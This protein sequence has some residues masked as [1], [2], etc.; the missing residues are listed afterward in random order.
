MATINNEDKQTRLGKAA[1]FFKQ[2]Q[3]IVLSVVIVVLVIIVTHMIIIE[4]RKKYIIVDAIEVPESLTQKGYN[5]S[6]IAR[7]LIDEMNRLKYVAEDSATY[8]LNPQD[9]SPTIGVSKEMNDLNFQIPETDISFSSILGFFRHYFNNKQITI[10]GD[11]IV[12]DKTV[13]INFRYG[14]SIIKHK[15]SIDKLNAGINYT[16]LELFKL[17]RPVTAA[18]Y[19]YAKKNFEEARVLLRNHLPKFSSTDKSE[20]L[21]ILGLIEN[22]KQKRD[23]AK[24]AM[25]FNMAIKENNYNAAAYNSLGLL[26]RSQKR[27][28]LAEICFLNAIRSNRQFS[29]AYVNLGVLKK[30][31]GDTLKAINYFE[32]A[33]E[34]NYKSS[35]YAHINLGIIKKYKGDYPGAEKYFQEAIDVAPLHADGYINLGLLKRDR[36]QLQEAEELYNQAL[37]INPKDYFIYNILGIVKRD[38]GFYREADSLFHQAINA[39]PNRPAYGYNNLGHLRRDEGLNSQAFAMYKTSS[40]ISPYAPNS[41][42][43]LGLIEAGNSNIEN[44]LSFYRQAIK[45]DNTAPNA[46]AYLGLIN[47]ENNPDRSVF[48]FKKAI[49]ANST[50]VDSYIYWFVLEQSRGNMLFAKQLYDRAIS[51]SP[52]NTSYAFMSYANLCRDQ[53]KLDMAI[54]LYKNA[55]TL[56]EKCIYAWINLIQVLKSKGLLKDAATY[57]RLAL[58]KN[59][60]NRL[61]IAHRL[62]SKKRPIS[63]KASSFSL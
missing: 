31:N 23:T 11:I 22:N 44:A 17:L 47:Q 32:Q 2:I 13:D 4:V 8:T 58:D 21:L 10:N 24:A 18:N 27:D 20:A 6:V 33:I 62:P 28:D 45:I 48:L 1:D 38:M 25:Y 5:G 15:T 16:A 3:T 61:L 51:I 43:Y 39:E 57:Y 29:S 52:I 37:K 54:E 34:K 40:V 41:L 46:Y 9:N 60:N 14:E 63:G 59:P 19:F 50:F 30:E 12:N 26:R 55:L 53:H 36:G 42:A 56:N 35:S 7:Y 49:K